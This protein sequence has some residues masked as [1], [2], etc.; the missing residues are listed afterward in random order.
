MTELTLAELR[1]AWKRVLMWNPKAPM[2]LYVIDSWWA[3][4]E[5]EMMPETGAELERE[6]YRRM[7]KRRNAEHKRPC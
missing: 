7:V 6:L 1:G 2:R 3:M 4:A 5:H